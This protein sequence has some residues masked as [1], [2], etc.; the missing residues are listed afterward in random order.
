MLRGKTENFDM[1]ECVPRDIQNRPFLT[2]PQCSDASHIHGNCAFF[3]PPPPPPFQQDFTLALIRL[4][5]Y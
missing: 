1:V 4:D 3:G 2:P 5:S